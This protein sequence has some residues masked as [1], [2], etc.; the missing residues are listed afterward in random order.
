MKELTSYL[1]PFFP[2]IGL[3]SVIA[4]VPPSSSDLIELL[5]STFPN[6][7]V[8]LRSIKGAFLFNGSEGTECEI[9]LQSDSAADPRE[10]KSSRTAVFLSLSR[11]SVPHWAHGHFW[12]LVYPLAGL[13]RPW[14]WQWALAARRRRP[15]VEDGRDRWW[16][17]QREPARAEAAWL[18]G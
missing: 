10:H 3:F 4:W 16:D 7:A 5:S 8:S 1:E 9:Q 6:V 17:H 14:M 15:G 18:P 13:T 12:V 11:L 2:L